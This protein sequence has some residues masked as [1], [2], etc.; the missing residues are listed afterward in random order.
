MRLDAPFLLL[1]FDAVALVVVL[2]SP[3]PIFDS[4]RRIRKNGAFLSIWKF[5]TMR[6]NSHLG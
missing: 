6:V 5:R 1:T 2:S 4:H 3:G